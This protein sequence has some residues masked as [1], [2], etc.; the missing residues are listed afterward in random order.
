MTNPDQNSLLV[1]KNVTIREAMRVM[2]SVG[3]KCLIISEDNKFFATISDGDI[4]KGLLD[5]V[6]LDAK[7]LQIANK[8][9]FAIK[10]SVPCLADTAIASIFHDKKFDL[11]PLVDEENSILDIFFWEDFLEAVDK[12]NELTLPIF[13]MAGGK[14][15]RLAPFTDVLP[16]P[17]IPI[18]GKTVIERIIEQF[19]KFN[20]TNFFISIN[21][22]AKILKAFFEEL[23][24]S[25]SL[26]FIEEDKPLGTGGS[27]VNLKD[28]M[29]E[30]FIL[31]NCDVI[32]DID[33]PDLVAFHAQACNAITLV[34]S[35]KEI[36]L[37]YGNITLD[38]NG[39]L[40]STE[41]KPKFDFL[42][43]TGMYV[44][45]REVLDLIDK[46]ESIDFPDLI[47]RATLNGLSVGVYPIAEDH[48]VD[49][50]QWAEYKNAI[51]KLS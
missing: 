43:N 28:L 31:T 41:E 44:V 35:T 9:P 25:Y 7:V 39:K 16:K 4:R 1:N 14:G 8:K 32:F 20:A 18:A 42:V 49:T 12:F 51:K 29:I 24:P 3:R 11:I 37:P 50:G 26:S 21:Y 46:D 36:Q 5:G 33:I 34:A 13:I 10:A 19:T 15:S 17:L 38:K 48:W 40:Q 22:K 6:S 2:T 47:Q 30:D 45:S 27:L 23:N